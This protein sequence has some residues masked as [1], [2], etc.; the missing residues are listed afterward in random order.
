MTAT[1]REACCSVTPRMSA[2]ELFARGFRR[3]RAAPLP[4]RGAART[5]AEGNA[6]A[7]S[8]DLAANRIAAVGFRVTTCAT[9]V[10]YCELIAETVPGFDI[11]IARA[12]SAADLI[13]ALEGVPEFKR[14]RAALAIEGF[15]AALDAAATHSAHSRASGNPTLGPRFRGDE[16]NVE[17]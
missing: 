3:N 10:A 8:L 6:A 12:F 9:L 17:N 13:D 4:V 15:R 1:C 2:S 5:D 7:F 14:G 16:R 11:E